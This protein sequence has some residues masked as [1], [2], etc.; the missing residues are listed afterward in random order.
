MFGS[1]K[2]KAFIR[3][4]ICI[5]IHWV[6][7]SDA[8]TYPQNKQ[9]EIYCENVQNLKSDSENKNNDTISQCDLLKTGCDTSCNN[10][11]FPTETIQDKFGAGIRTCCGGHG[12][13]FRNECEVK[14][15]SY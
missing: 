13:V 6:C 12:Y 15:N 3:I 8:Q 2:T 14:P 4:F 5:A 11:K 10:E 7:F 1:G 9:G